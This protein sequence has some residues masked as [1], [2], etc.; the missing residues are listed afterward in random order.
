MN[1]YEEIIFEIL[2][3]YFKYKFQHHVRPQWLLNPKTGRCLELDFYSEEGKIA[4]EVNGGLHYNVRFNPN[5]E[6]QKY[7][8]TLKAKIL[9][10]RG[11]RLWVIN[12]ATIRRKSNYW[13]NVIENSNLFTLKSGLYW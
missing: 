8:D 13:A 12:S 3:R 7:R 9:K 6:D 4:I 5:L 10:D 11:I 1:S 2:P